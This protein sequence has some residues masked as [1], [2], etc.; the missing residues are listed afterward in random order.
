MKQHNLRRYIKD[1]DSIPFLNP[2]SNNK[3]KRSAISNFFDLNNAEDVGAAGIWSEVV[4]YLNGFRQ[5][6]KNYYMS[7]PNCK[8]K[9]AEEN[10]ST[11][12]NC[13][14]HYQAARYRYILT[15]NLTDHL[16]SIWATAYDEVGEKLLATGGEAL[17][18]GDFARM[19][20]Q[21]V[22][23]LMRGLRFRQVKL[24]MVTKNEE[25]NNEMRKK[26]N[27]IKLVELNYAEESRLVLSKL[28]QLLAQ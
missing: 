23:E 27:I 7:C 14:Q 19:S 2:S 17:P 6:G 26:T 21:E 15:L 3:P 1:M 5:S 20:E 18:A 12:A 22:Q 16:D 13:S 4:C 25:F 28:A 9:V 10:D 8:K 24:R 11:C